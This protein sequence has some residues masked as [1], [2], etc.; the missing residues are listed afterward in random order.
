MV[1]I[2]HAENQ[3]DTNVIQLSALGHMWLKDDARG[4]YKKEIHGRWTCNN[5]DPYMHMPVTQAAKEE[6]KYTAVQ[7]I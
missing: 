4:E 1:I 3:M 7:G 5:S 2:C 6:K